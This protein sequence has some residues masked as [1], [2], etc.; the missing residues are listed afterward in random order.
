MDMICNINYYVVYSSVI[1]IHDG[2]S[3]HQTRFTSLSS[4]LVENLQVRVTCHMPHPCP[5]GIQADTGWLKDR[6]GTNVRL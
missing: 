2:K 4:C 3:P 1:L 5:G 6:H